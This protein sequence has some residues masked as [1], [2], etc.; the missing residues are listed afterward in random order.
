MPDG[1]LQWRI[2]LGAERC[3]CDF[4]KTCLDEELA[5][6]GWLEAQPDVTLFPQHFVVVRQ[7]VHDDEVPTGT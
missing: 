4:Y 2:F 7:V 3:R 6:L 1:K 5:Q